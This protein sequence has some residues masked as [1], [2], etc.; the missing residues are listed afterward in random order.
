MRWKYWA[1]P[2]S[3]VNQGQPRSVCQIGAIVKNPALTEDRVANS[4]TIQITDVGFGSRLKQGPG[5]RFPCVSRWD[6]R[7]CL[8]FRTTTN[9]S[10]GAHGVEHAL[11]DLLGTGAMGNIWRFGFEQL[12]MRQND[13]ELVIQL[14]EQQTELWVRD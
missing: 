4:L 6:L 3:S 10:S 14:V 13:A 8:W 5:N 12:R 1:L 7:S 9:L 2:T 11:Y